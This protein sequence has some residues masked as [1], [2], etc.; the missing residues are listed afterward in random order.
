MT[1]ICQLLN[2]YALILLVRIIL[3]WVTMFWSPPSYLSAGIRVI[4]DLTEPVLGFV[5]R[6]VPPIGGLDL[7]PLVVFIGIRLVCSAL[8]G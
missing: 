5:R 8:V 7:S 3:S 6:Y 4:Y 2:L 1:L